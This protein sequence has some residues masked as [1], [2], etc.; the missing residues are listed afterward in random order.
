MIRAMGAGTI[1]RLVSHGRWGIFMLQ[2]IAG[3]F[4]FPFKIKSCLLEVK[5]IGADSLSIIGFTALFT[6]MVLGLQGY[7]TL[8]QFGA[9][10]ALGIGVAITLFSELGPVLT[11][12]LL[13]G[14][15]GSSMCAQI[16]VMRISEQ[17]DALET[18]GID[19]FHYI[20][21]PKLVGGLIAFPILTFLFSLV[22][23]W[24][25]YIAGVMI[26]GV[27]PGEY[28]AG[29]VKALHNDKII[30]MCLVKSLVFGALMIM[31]STFQGYMV[32]NQKLKGAIGV[33]KA[34]TDAVVYTSVNVLL[35]DYL[36][37]SILI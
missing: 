31:I 36:L 20:I 9:D 34:T 25:A 10:S 27:N 5:T 7:S 8:K 28:Y 32:L 35:W 11:A 23:V 15:A 6:G 22:G 3:V 13:T 24:G 14:R 21:S 2:V 30:P 19:P 26:L 37:T 12:L 16:G 17:I 1:R 29:I 18:M 4:K 33:S